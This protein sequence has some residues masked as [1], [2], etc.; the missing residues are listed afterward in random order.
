MTRGEQPPGA[1]PYRSRSA[2]EVLMFL[3]SRQITTR[4]EIAEH[5]GLSAAAVTKAL[6]P[7]LEAGLIAETS[8]PR[9]SGVGAGRPTQQVRIVGSRVTVLGIKLTADEVIAVVTNL[10]GVIIEQ[11][12][13]PLPEPVG[14]LDVDPVINEVAAVVADLSGRHRLDRVGVA[15]SGDVDTERG[16]V[17]LSP[18]LGWRDVPFAERLASM[19][20][21]P[22]IIDND[23]RALTAAE[24]AFGDAFG[25]DNFAVVTIGEGIGCGL[26]IGG[27]VLRGAF[28]VAGELGHMII[29][30]AGLPDADATAGRPQLGQIERMISRQAVMLRAEGAVSTEPQSFAELITAAAAGDTAAGRLLE[31]VGGELGIGIA[32][33]VNLIGPQRLVI[34][35]EGFDLDSAF[36][37]LV[38]EVIRRHA[39]GQAAQVEI[40]H[41]EIPFS[42]WAR[43]AAVVALTRQVLPS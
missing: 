36:G 34:S 5:T 24:Q 30:A 38:D 42:E 12:R 13:H 18:L 11:V 9:G 25:I 31:A 37:D 2:A 6:R 15:I 14:T 29:N 17:V 40:I 33:V 39:F 10:S 22:V 27:Q 32:N 20:G 41:R 21:P 1:A 7:M 19:I 23:I 3:L 16:V 43:G 26:V 8:L 4:R 35:S 28:G